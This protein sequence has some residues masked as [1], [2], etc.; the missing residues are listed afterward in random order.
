MPR[1]RRPALGLG[2]AT[3]AFLTYSRLSQDNLPDYGIPWVPA[4]TN[5]VLGAYSDQPAPVDFDNFYGLS[6]RDFEQTTT[7]L[8]SLRLEHDFSDSISLRNLTRYGI[9]RRDSVITA[10]RFLN[11]NTGTT[12]NRQLQSP[13]QEDSILA[14]QTDLTATFDT[15]NLNHT[16]VGSVEFS[17]ETSEN[18]ARTQF[19]ANATPTAEL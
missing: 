19:A 18:F 13:D 8:P 12:I 17:H 4:N 3:R 14:N 7:D 11:A 9:T 2:T 15:W 16:A 10:P 6:S 1:S 5:A